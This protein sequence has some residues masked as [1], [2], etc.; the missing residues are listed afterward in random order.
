MMK[1]LVLLVARKKPEIRSQYFDIQKTWHEKWITT[2]SRR[3]GN[4]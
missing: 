3:A 1:N 2:I 4:R